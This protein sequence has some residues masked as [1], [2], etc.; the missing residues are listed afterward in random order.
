MI[1]NLPQYTKYYV[2][3]FMRVK[4]RKV[5]LNIQNMLAN[6]IICLK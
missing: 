5:K 2:S 1:Q 4:E 3:M 6:N